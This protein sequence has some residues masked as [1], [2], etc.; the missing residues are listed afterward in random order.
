M[1]KGFLDFSPALNIFMGRFL[2][3]QLGFFAII[4]AV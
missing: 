1:G 2:A 4:Q 3:S